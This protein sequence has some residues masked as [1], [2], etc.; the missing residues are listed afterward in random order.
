MT[1]R[2]KAEGCFGVDSVAVLLLS[3]YQGLATVK[4][5]NSSKVYLLSCYYLKAGIILNQQLFH[6]DKL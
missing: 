2:F 1:Q 6:N 4:P 5:S 3:I